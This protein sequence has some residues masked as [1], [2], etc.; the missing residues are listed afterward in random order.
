[1]ITAKDLL[2]QLPPSEGIDEDIQEVA[3]ILAKALNGDIDAAER[4]ISI[5]DNEK[6]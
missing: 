3:G 6:E 5:W 2:K 1:M 4:I